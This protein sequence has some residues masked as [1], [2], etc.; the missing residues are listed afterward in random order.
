MRKSR[1]RDRLRKPRRVF[2]HSLGLSSAPRRADCSFSMALM[3]WPVKCVPPWRRPAFNIE[4]G[5]TGTDPAQDNNG[6]SFVMVMEPIVELFYF[7]FGP[8]QTQTLTLASQVKLQSASQTSTPPLPP[9]HHC[10][11]AVPSLSARA[12]RAH[13]SS[14][15][16]RTPTDKSAVS[17]NDDG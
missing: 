2:G 12:P 14:V 11:Q 15:I 17:A 1:R 5:T 16:I 8:A 6:R 10:T 3:Y 9:Q 13:L 4:C 7:P